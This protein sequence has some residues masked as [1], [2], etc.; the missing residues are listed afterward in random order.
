MRGFIL[1]SSLQHP[2][3]HPHQLPRAPISF[4][5]PVRM[6]QALDLIRGDGTL[7]LQTPAEVPGTSSHPLNPRVLLQPLPLL[8]SL[9]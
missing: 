6:S 5:I 8:K 1:L 4:N 2:C 3:L 9:T 7:A